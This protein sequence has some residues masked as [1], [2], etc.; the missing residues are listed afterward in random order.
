MATRPQII[1][2]ADLS[3]L[4]TFR[5][6]ARTA[7]LITLARLSEL[8]HI[9]DNPPPFVLGGGS[10]TL[11]LT[12]YPGTIL[13]NRLRGVTAQALDE[14]RVRV[15]A[16][17]GEN[18]HR[19]VRR[20]LH[21]GLY[22]LENLAMIPGSVGAAPMQNI[23][24]YGAELAQVLD[25][26]DVWDWQAREHR[27]LSAA[28]CRLGYRS[29]RFRDGDRGRFL[30]TGVHLVLNKCPSVQTAYASLK[31]E[32]DRCGLNHPAPRQI[33]A[34][35]MRVRRHRLPDPNRI[36]NAGSFFK[37]PVVSPDTADR[38][39]ETFPDLPHWRLGG[40]TKISAAWMIDQLGWKGKTLGNAG[41]YANHALVL[42]NRGGAT[43]EEVLALAHS[44]HGDVR[45]NFGISLAP[46]PLL[47]T[48]L[49]TAT[50]SPDAAP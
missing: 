21:H 40:R 29:S 31:S 4:S 42:V 33:A 8:Q 5:L 47:L 38:L 9:P 35:V 1:T 36:A 2:N 46:E 20:C 22:G 26:V 11:F 32:L 49:D 37:N 44:I 41:V 28:E 34:A 30:V 15:S 23:G 43:G 12:D 50:P 27:R 17:A 19:L 24:A 48:G 14:H 7:R 10:N 13:L 6:P 39:L 45:E 3:Q 18:W 16:A 25:A